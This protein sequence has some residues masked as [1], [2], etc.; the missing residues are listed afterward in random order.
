MKIFRIFRKTNSDHFPAYHPRNSFL[1]VQR[2]KIRK[3]NLGVPVDLNRPREPSA[4]A[5]TIVG[6]YKI[7]HFYNDSTEKIVNNCN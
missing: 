5:R 6:C 1:D 7:L 2:A 3:K 4:G